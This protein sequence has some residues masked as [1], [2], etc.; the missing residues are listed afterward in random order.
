MLIGHSMGGLVAR[1]ACAAALERGADWVELVSHTVSLGTPHLGAPM[2]Q[3]TAQTVALMEKVPELRPVG[4]WLRSRSV[5]IKWL[6]HGALL[7][8]DVAA[9]IDDPHEDPRTCVPL[10]P[11]GRHHV[12]AVTLTEDPDRLLSRVLGDG[13]VL[14]PSAH[15]RHRDE[16]RSIRFETSDVHALG[17]LHHF[18]LLNHPRVYALLRTCVRSTVVCAA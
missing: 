11:H 6:R 12:L 16:S 8:P 13:L 15:G 18:D 17:G 4:R 14:Q 2:E 9:D 10:L 7:D 1:S 3:R 5:G